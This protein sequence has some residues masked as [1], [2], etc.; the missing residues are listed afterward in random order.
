MPEPTQPTAPVNIP[1]SVGVQWCAWH[2]AYST[3]TRR[4]RDTSGAVLNACYSCR[5]AFDL[6]PIADPPCTPAS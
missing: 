3:T 1:P 4:V 2:E 5:Q 6:A